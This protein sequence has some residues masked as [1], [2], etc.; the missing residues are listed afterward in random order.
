MSIPP[1]AAFA[2]T[3]WTLV[4]AA[5]EAGH[6][7]N[8][9]ALEELCRR[10]WYPL[11]AFVRREGYDAHQAQDLTQGFFELLLERNDL[12]GLVRGEGRFR[13][14]LLKALS[15]HLLDEHSRAT[16]AKRGG[17]NRVLSLDASDSEE[18]FLLEPS[19]DETPERHFE[20][21]WALAVLESAMQELER[22][23][24]ASGKGDEFA[25]LKPFLAREPEPGEYATLSERMGLAAGTLAV[26]VHRLRHQYRSLVRTAV[27]DTVDGPLAAEDEMRHLLA[28]L[29]GKSSDFP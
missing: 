11:Y 12:A 16:A 15:R 21:Q 20:R 24:I 17:R 2:T 18:R 3:R 29:S 10:Y 8:S 26:Q 7:E 27:A 19:H 25:V 22:R 9:A 28:A 1:S 4:L 14:F 5:G 6:P 23:Q 13:S